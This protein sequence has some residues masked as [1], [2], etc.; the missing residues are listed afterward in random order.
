MKEQSENTLKNN[1]LLHTSQFGFRVDHSKTFQCMML[2]D[3][4]SLN[5]NN[6]MSTA[7][8]FLDIEEG[9]DKTLRTGLQYKL[10]EYLQVFSRSLIKLIASLS[11]RESLK[12]W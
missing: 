10:S 12:S 6:N 4:I 1:N 11:V 7:A 5:F 8:V 9:F 2:E 3:H